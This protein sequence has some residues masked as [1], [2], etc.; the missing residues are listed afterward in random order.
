MINTDGIVKIGIML[1]GIVLGAW[2]GE[3]AEYVIWTVGDYAVPYCAGQNL[4]PEWY[5]LCLKNLGNY[6]EVKPF[7]QLAGVLVG[8]VVSVT[9]VKRLF[10]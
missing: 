1:A 3:L 7:F 4:P 10:D 2:A 9:A 6:N 8:L 5:E